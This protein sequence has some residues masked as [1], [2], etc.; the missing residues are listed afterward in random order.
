MNRPR[1]ILALAICFALLASTG[2]QA[3]RAAN[4]D[5]TTSNNTV[6][7]SVSVSTS[8]VF[9]AYFCSPGDN[10][11]VT[12][13]ALGSVALT[14]TSPETTVQTGGLVICY[15]DSKPLRPEFRTYIQSGNFSGPGSNSLSASGFKVTK[16]YWIAQTQWSSQ[17]PPA[18]TGIGDIGQVNGAGTKNASDGGTLPAVYG[19][20]TTNNS[21]DSWRY[22]HYGYEGRGTANGTGLFPSV[23][24]SGDPHMGSFGVIEVTID[25][26]DSTPAGTYSATVTLQVNFETP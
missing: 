11:N 8:G 2:L 26:P 18:T 3:A 15:R 20:W 16:T 4:D 5:D 22:V 24:N 14:S 25:I 21:L 6:T 23:W 9:D 12:S 13:G 7:A 10:V 17:N 19:A 1:S